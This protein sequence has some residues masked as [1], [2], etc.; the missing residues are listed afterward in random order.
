MLAYY[1]VPGTQFSTYRVPTAVG[2]ATSE[3]KKKIRVTALNT[4][5]IYI[6]TISPVPANVLIDAPD[7]GVHSVLKTSIILTF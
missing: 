7:H 6:F 4:I 1:V 2:T 5:N 3:L